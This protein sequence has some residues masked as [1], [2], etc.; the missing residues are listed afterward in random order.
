MAA[1]PELPNLV[2]RHIAMG[3]TLVEEECSVAKGAVVTE[4]T[5]ELTEAGV[6]A[7]LMA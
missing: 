3:L 5:V 7:V 1:I 6:L 4:S 2:S